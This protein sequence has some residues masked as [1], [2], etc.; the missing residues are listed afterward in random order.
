MATLCAGPFSIFFLVN[1]IT[2]THTHKNMPAVLD[3]QDNNKKKPVSV[4]FT[5]YSIDELLDERNYLKKNGLNF[6]EIDNELKRRS[7]FYG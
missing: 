7:N 6:Y 2:H 4:G 5:K 3:P 1:I